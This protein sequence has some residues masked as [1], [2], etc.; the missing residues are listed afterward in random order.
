[1]KNYKILCIA[2]MTSFTFSGCFGDKKTVIGQETG[3]DDLENKNFKGNAFSFA[4]LSENLCGYIDMNTVQK[5]FAVSG[6][7]DAQEDPKRRYTGK[8]CDFFLTFDNT[9]SKY[10][11]GNLTVVEDISEDE[12]D[13]QEQWEW[14]KKSLKSAEYVSGLGKAA[15]W[16]GKQRKLEVKMD[17]YTLF[18]VVPPTYTINDKN[19]KQHDYKN[20]AIAI[21]KNSKFFKN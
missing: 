9:P 4:K 6:A 19:A 18:L 2:L 8:Y 16:I 13:W 17:G 11:R 20:S 10:S 1:M 5:Q 3:S 14:R 15:I 7:T 12:A 21:L